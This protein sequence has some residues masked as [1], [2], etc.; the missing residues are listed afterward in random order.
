MLHVNLLLHCQQGA[1]V[2]LLT[3]CCLWCHG[4]G[5][6][7]AFLADHK[8]DGQILIPVNPW[9]SCLYTLPCTAGSVEHEVH[10]NCH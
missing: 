1:V 10:D 2:V 3:G 9:P 4:S 8:V 5:G 6:E 7:H